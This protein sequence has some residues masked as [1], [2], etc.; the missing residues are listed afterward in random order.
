[1]SVVFVDVVLVTPTDSTG[2]LVD[3]TNSSQVN[4]FT[5]AACFVL[6]VKSLNKLYTVISF[7]KKTHFHI[8]L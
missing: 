8:Q 1:M 2:M 7:I 3:L 4:T 6:L 5:P